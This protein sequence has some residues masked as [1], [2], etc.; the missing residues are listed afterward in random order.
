MFH[1]NTNLFKGGSPLKYSGI[2]NAS[3]SHVKMVR[4]KDE[5][6]LKLDA[7]VDVLCKNKVTARSANQCKLQYK[8]FIESMQYEHGDLLLKYDLN[9]GT[10]MYLS[11]EKKFDILWSVSKVIMILTCG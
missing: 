1:D 7:Q 4:K 10:L 6:I 3:L 8:K 9:W 11:N 2:R 5:C